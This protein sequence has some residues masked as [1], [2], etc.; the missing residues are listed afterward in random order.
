[1]E[2]LPEMLTT[3]E[4]AALFLKTPRT[5]TLWARAGTLMGLRP[6]GGKWLFP[7]N[8]PAIAAQIAAEVRALQEAEEDTVGDA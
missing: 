5:I 3:N 8:Q 7:S 1:M 4:V 6:T 2:E